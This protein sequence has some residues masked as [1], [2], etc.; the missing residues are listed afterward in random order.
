MNIQ[1][2]AMF[3]CTQHLMPQ[4]LPSEP[5]TIANGAPGTGY[6]T[7][8]EQGVNGEIIGKNYVVRGF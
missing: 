2:G 1:T 7:P 3:I 6:A 4:A 8:Q 5:P